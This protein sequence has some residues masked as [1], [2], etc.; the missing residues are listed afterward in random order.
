MTTQV[1]LAFEAEYTERLVD[2]IIAILETFGA[3]GVV[4]SSVPV[5]LN[6]DFNLYA[7]FTD[8][9]MNHSDY[10][11]Y[12]VFAGVTKVSAKATMPTNYFDKRYVDED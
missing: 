11:W 1:E 9:N 3:Q 6:E 4:V 5:L 2:K 10:W 7:L 8:H 12:A